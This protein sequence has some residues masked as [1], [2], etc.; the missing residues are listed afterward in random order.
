MLRLGFGLLDH[1]PG[2]GVAFL[3]VLLQHFFFDAPL[4]TSADLDC[5]ELAASDQGISRGGVDLKLF[6]NIGE[7]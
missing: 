1:A 5:F 7:R 6:G 4:P 3:D 2:F